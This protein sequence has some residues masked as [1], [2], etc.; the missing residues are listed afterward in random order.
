[1]TTRISEENYLFNKP[2]VRPSL[3]IKKKL[4]DKLTSIEVSR[5][6]PPEDLIE[7]IDSIRAGV[8]AKLL[9]QDGV[10]PD[11][12]ARLSIFDLRILFDVYRGRF[13]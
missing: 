5:D 7:P 12:L 4:E 10:S 2:W 11:A 6:A 1:M 8:G 9:A 3:D 13:G